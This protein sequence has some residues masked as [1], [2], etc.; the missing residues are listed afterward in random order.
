MTFDYWRER[1]IAD[2]KRVLD[3][4]PKICEECPFL[5]KVVPLMGDFCTFHWNTQ[6]RY[7]NSACDQ[8]I[9]LKELI[10]LL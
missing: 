1:R 6:H 9:F 2:L 3:R 10:R 8:I 7:M 5:Q 4:R